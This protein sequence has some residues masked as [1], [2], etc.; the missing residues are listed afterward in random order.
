MN[1]T[2]LSISGLR[3]TWLALIATLCASQSTQAQRS[4]SLRDHYS[5]PL[6]GCIP[7]PGQYAMDQR[8]NWILPWEQNDRDPSIIKLDI[9]VTALADL[10][11]SFITSAR[12]LNGV[13][14]A[15][16]TNI[17]VGCSTYTS[18]NTLEVIAKLNEPFLLVIQGSTVFTV[19]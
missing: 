6:I 7:Q 4:K 1:I 15:S 3:I 17:G 10:G 13:S 14:M 12:N 2:T 8:K 19:G 5:G 18:T 9:H 11:S 16:M